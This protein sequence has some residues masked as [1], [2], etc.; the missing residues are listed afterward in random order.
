MLLRLWLLI[1]VFFLMGL[2][3]CSSPD[4]EG[5]FQIEDS[6]LQDKI[7]G[8]WLGKTA[9]VCIGFPTEFKSN[10]KMYEGEINLEA[11]L[12]GGFEQDD[13][14]GQAN[15]IHCLDSLSSGPQGIF[16]ATMMDYAEVL[17]QSQYKLWHGDSVGRNNLQKGIKAPDCGMWAGEGKRHNIHAHCIDWQINCDF[18]GIISPGQPLSA[19]RLSDSV[20]H[21]MNYGDGLYGGHF[22]SAMIALAFKSNDVHEIVR[23]ALKTIPPPSQY[24]RVISDVMGF[25]E[26]V[27]DKKY[28]DCWHFINNKYLNFN[29]HCP[30]DWTPDFNIMASFNGAFVVIALLYGNGDILKTIEY[31]VRCGQDS[32]CNAASAASVLG[33]MLGYKALPAAWKASIEKYP[34]R[35]YSYTNYTYADLVNTSIKLAQQGIK[36]A[37]GRFK[38]GIHTLAFAPPEPPALWE[39]YG[40]D[41]V[42]WA[43]TQN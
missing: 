31:A 29:D 14:Y 25:Y 19:V 39:K 42:T 7:K 1:P 6:V 8:A 26:N 13:I 36:Q 15:F 28:T 37:G 5:L 41:P 33:A 23:E 2:S 21:I 3:A 27:P 20:G 24:Y 30:E 35:K 9:G 17:K 18:V 22:V 16:T 38:D 12:G 43:E 11:D 32:D 10:G 40:Q 4:P 34:D